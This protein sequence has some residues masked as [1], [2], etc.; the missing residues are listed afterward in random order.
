MEGGI[1]C[2]SHATWR[3]IYY[4]QAALSFLCVVCGWLVLEPE[5]S[6]R[7]YIKGLDLGG[8][9]LSTAGIGMLTYCLALVSHKYQGALGLTFWQRSFDC[10]ERLGIST[11]CRVAC[12]FCRYPG[13]FPLLRTLEGDVASICA[14]ATEYVETPRRQDG[15]YDI[16]SIFWLVGTFD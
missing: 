12:R 11:H 13:T 2:K 6:S 9:F 15:N 7:R 5:A 14:D 8:A 10:V 4:I 3:A 1:L 16:A